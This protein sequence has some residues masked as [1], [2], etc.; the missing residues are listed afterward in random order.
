MTHFSKITIIGVGLIGGSFAY[1]CKRKRL[2]SHIMGF[3][4]SEANLKK[5]VT[6][7]VIDS[8]T[9]DLK[10]AV[11]N[12]ELVLIAAPVMAIVDIVKKSLPYLKN[13][14]IITDA[15]SVKYSIVKEIEKIIGC[16][17]F[18]FVGVHPIAG[19]EK[20]GIEAAHI[21]LFKD[22][23]CIITP[24]DN[25]NSG[26]LDKIERIWKE[27]GSETV[28]MDA[29]MHDRILASVSHLPHV[30]VY[31]LVN[32]VSSFIDDHEDIKQF[33]AGG[34]KDTTR[35][36]SSDPVMWRDICILNKN[37]II[38]SIDLFQTILQQIRGCIESEDL[39]GL[40]RQFKAARDVRDEI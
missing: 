19:K 4:R 36:A 12:V 33:A 31:S 21:G 8:Y 39:E 3:G 11:S 13:N 18:Y 10:E 1:E 24:T 37:N 28:I 30:I 40:E 6:L 25:T 34:F 35:I 7:N 32:A 26:A 23:K 29:E 14:V 9:L 17:D 27:M 5:A 16:R 20:S 2:V 38:R 15:G 22:S